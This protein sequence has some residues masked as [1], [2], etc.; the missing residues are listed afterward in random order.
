MNKPIIGIVGKPTI[1]SDMWNYM[2]I[3]DDIR[4]TILK[5]NAIAIGILP[6]DKKINFK[7]DEEL[8]NYILTNDEICDLEIIIEN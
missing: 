5:N 7:V 4:Y 3:V 6:T 2:E 8:D 1:E